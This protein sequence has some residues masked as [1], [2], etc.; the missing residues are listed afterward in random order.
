MVGWDG[1]R[2]T[3][4]PLT[5]AAPIVSDAVVAAAYSG[6]PLVSSQ[7]A[8]SGYIMQLTSTSTGAAPAW[9]DDDNEVDL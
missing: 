7:P 5:V 2:D 6:T 1:M 9:G 4:S 3:V 8:P